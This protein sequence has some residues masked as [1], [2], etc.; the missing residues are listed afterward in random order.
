M[1]AAADDRQDP[2]EPQTGS[3]AGRESSAEMDR[4]GKPDR[5]KTDRRRQQVPVSV[6]RRRGADR[7]SGRD[8]RARQGPNTYDLEADE[9]EFVNAV[10]RFKERTGRS[11]PTWSEVLGILRDLGYEKRDRTS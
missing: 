4:R 5:R 8:R 1:S 3:D 11:F 7:R 6:D 2:S 10:Q 9:L